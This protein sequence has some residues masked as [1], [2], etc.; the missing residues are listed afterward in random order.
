[1]SILTKQKNPND[2]RILRIDEWM[3]ARPRAPLTIK[4]YHQDFSYFLKW[5][6]TAW[7][8]VDA[9]T[10]TSFN[11][12][13]QME[14]EL[15]SVTIARILGTL[16]QFFDW[17]FR[18]GYISKDPTI[19]VQIPSWPEPKTRNLSDEIFNQIVDVVASLSFPER[20][21]ALIAVLSHGLRPG[22]PTYLD[23]KDYDGHRLHIRQAKHNSTGYV[24]LDDW[25]KKLLD[26]YLNWRQLSGSVL[27]PDSPLFISHSNRNSGERITYDAIRYL[28]KKIREKTG[29]Y[30]NAH[31]FRHTFATNLVLEGMNPYHVMTLTRHKSVKNFRRYTQTADQEAADNAFYEHVKNHPGIRRKKQ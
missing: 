4:A 24:P 28:V 7:E 30:F 19:A 15:S 21:L 20:N 14:T 31:Q 13:L 6:S 12:Y 5:T 10:I 2:H 27:Q 29:V 8:E 16:R 22:E 26:E 23:I 9:F 1:M 3:S 18:S 11:Q 17:M 25:A